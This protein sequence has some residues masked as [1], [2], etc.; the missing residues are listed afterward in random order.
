MFREGEL[1]FIVQLLCVGT[2]RGAFCTL[3]HLSPTAVSIKA[4]FLSVSSMAFRNPVLSTC[5]ASSFITTSFAFGAHFFQIFKCALF[6]VPFQLP[7][8]L[9]PYLTLPSPHLCAPHN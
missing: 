9:L 8:M 7:H 6:A 2:A 3:S 5:P 1:M 4:S